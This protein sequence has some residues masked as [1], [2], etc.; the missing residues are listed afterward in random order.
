MPGYS[1]LA[2]NKDVKWS[3]Q[4][5]RNFARDRHTATRK[6]QDYDV[7]SSRICAEP[8]CQ[9]LA[10]MLAVSKTLDHW[11]TLAELWASVA[12]TE[13]SYPCVQ[14]EGSPVI[15]EQIVAGFD[16]PMF[17]VTVAS[18]NEVSGCLVGFTSQCS[19]DP[20]RFLVCLSKKNHTFHVAQESN[21]MAVHLVPADRWELA[22]SF[23]GETGDELDKFENLDWTPGPG[24]VPVLALCPTW[25][26]GPIIDRIDGG[27][28]VVH[29]IEPTTGGEGARTSLL[30][31]QKARRIEPGHEA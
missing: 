13:R 16:Y 28:H 29:M 17:I 24:G 4:G 6:T 11:D 5:A 26:A 15:F 21:C 18:S 10:S 8:P 12:G 2:D 25:F 7:G 27:D 30:M 9:D 19:I 31:F 22:A 20:F 23:G 3:A 14:T 1:D